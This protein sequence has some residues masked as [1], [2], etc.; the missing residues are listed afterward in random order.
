MKAQFGEARVPAVP[1]PRRCHEAVNE[2]CTSTPCRRRPRVVDGLARVREHELLPCV[3]VALESV[4]Y[5][6]WRCVTSV[7][8]Y[9]RENGSDI[10]NTIESTTAPPLGSMISRLAEAKHLVVLSVASDRVGDDHGPGAFRPNPG[11]IWSLSQH[12]WKCP[13][14]ST[15]LCTP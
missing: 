15:G 2:F 11:F 7:A 12:R 14:N 3:R 1:K 8:F 4:D 9:S 10:A 13:A 6:A 5:S